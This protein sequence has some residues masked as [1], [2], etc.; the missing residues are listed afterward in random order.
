MNKRVL[1]TG[2]PGRDFLNAAL[3]RLHA[4]V[5]VCACTCVG[6]QALSR[7]GRFA[8]SWTVAHQALCP[9]SHPARDTGVG[10][11]AL[12][13]GLFRTQGSSLCLLW[14]LP[15]QVDSCPL[16]HLGDSLS[17]LGGVE[18]SGQAGKSGGPERSATPKLALLQGGNTRLL[19]P[20][21][22]QKC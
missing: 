3:R 6:E 21:C 12:F 5:H 16:S 1:T 14:L 11:H 20:I 17:W 9:W 13:S 7:V 2:P 10:R 15:R 4:Y 8:T 22:E 18:S 19:P